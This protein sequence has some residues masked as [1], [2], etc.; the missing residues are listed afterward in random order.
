MEFCSL[1]LIRYFAESVLFVICPEY[2]HIDQKNTGVLISIC[3]LIDVTQVRQLRKQHVS[4]ELL[5]F[6]MM[7]KLAALGES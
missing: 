6:W 5:S 7:L 3:Y 4:A 1:F 2:Q